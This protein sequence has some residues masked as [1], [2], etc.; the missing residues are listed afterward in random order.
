MLPSAEVYDLAVVRTA[1]L[2]I[3]GA[4]LGGV[5]GVVATLA[6]HSSRAEAPQPDRVVGVV[7]R[8]TVRGNG[9]S[10]D[11]EGG[12]C[13][14]IRASYTATAGVAIVN[15][16]LELTVRTDKGTTY[17]VDVPPS[18]TVTVGDPWPKP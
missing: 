8:C 4:I 1:G 10:V 7:E 11:L 5:I 16:R 18:A 2:I 3:A 13:S 12:T 15:T 9:Q 14:D 17:T 6:L